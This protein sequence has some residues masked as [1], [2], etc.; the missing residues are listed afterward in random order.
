MIFLRESGIVIV[1]IEF[2]GLGA[3]FPAAMGQGQSRSERPAFKQT[4]IK[5]TYKEEHEYG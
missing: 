4:L 3:A 2:L 1:S 5:K